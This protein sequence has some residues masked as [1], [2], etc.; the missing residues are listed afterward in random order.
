M[1][2]DMIDVHLRDDG[3][4]AWADLTAG[5]GGQCLVQSWAYAEAKARIGPW[6]VER[7]LL[8]D[9]GRPVGA[10]QALVRRLPYGLPGGLAWINRGPLWA[11]GGR[12][13]RHP[14]AAMMAALRRHYVDERHFYLRL[15]PP[16]GDDALT[17]GVDDSAGLV[18]TRTPGWASAEVDL[19]PDVEQ[20]RRN[21]RGDWRN[22]LGKGKR[23][24][25][26]IRAGSDPALFADFIA[27]YRAFLT[28]RGFATTVTPELLETLQGLLLP[29][30]RLEAFLGIH[31]GVL[32]GSALMATTGDRAEYLAGHVEHDVRDLGVGQTLLWEALLAMKARGVA[33]F[34]V[35]GLD[36]DLTPKGILHFKGGLGGTPYRLAA[37]REAGGG[38]VL[39]RLVRWRVA[40]ARAAA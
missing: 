5:F 14:L 23:S 29:E 1:I 33:I 25:L 16:V 37:E 38:G 11:G 2:A 39:G 21:L 36:P 9:A 32:V 40:H 19:S 35:G 8:V 7:G 27:A 10:F 26:T 4:A 12:P 22:K 34:D 17:A 15:A 20:L 6:R 31:D 3:Q 24:G 13:D 18:A 28:N 30:R